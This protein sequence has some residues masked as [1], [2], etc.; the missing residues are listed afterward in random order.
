M[1]KDSFLSLSESVYRV[2]RLSASTPELLELF[3]EELQS[4]KR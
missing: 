2:N 3:L 1:S 4:P